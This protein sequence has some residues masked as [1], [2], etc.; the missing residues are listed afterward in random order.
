[1]MLRHNRSLNVDKGV[2]V[3][4]KKCTYTTLPSFNNKSRQLINACRWIVHALEQ[5]IHKIP[6]VIHDTGAP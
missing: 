4:D 3:V 1:M 5:V 2:R 6:G